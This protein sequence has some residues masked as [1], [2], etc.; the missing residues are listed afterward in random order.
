MA[1][2]PL[3]DMETI[4]CRSPEPRIYGREGALDG[5]SGYGLAR[6]FLA[7]LEKW[8][9]R[10]TVS[11]ESFATFIII[12]IV[13]FDG[14]CSVVLAF[15][16]SDTFPYISGTSA[17]AYGSWFTTQVT[18]PVWLM[19]NIR[20]K[21]AAFREGPLPSNGDN[22][23]ST[24]SLAPCLVE[25]L[26]SIQIDAGSIEMSDGVTSFLSVCVECQY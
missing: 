8:T 6:E 5:P 18:M 14:I 11:M 26:V 10:R 12:S 15:H 7:S 20:V 25:P 4:H 19:V 9:A 24:S 1:L 23:V 16:P 21:S 2:P 17:S 22:F 13:E 3:T